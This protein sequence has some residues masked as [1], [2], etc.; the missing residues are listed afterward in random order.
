LLCRDYTAVSLCQGSPSTNFTITIGNTDLCDD[1]PNVDASAGLTTSLETYYDAALQIPQA[2]FQTGDMVYFKLAVRDPSST[3]DQITFRSIIVR[4]SDAVVEDDL[5]ETEN[6]GDLPSEA[7]VFRADADFNIT[8][9]FRTPFLV[10]N[11]EGDL[12]FNFRLLRNKLQVVSALSSNSADDMTKQLTI[13]AVIDLLYH[14]NQVVTRTFVA[15]TNIPAMTHAQ[16]SFYD[17]GET[18]EELEPHANDANVAADA[19][20]HASLFAASPASTVVASCVAVLAAAA[21]ILA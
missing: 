1:A 15:T 5:Y 10:P 3:I 2:I 8:Q 17:M 7:T 9:E 6:A 13:E 12:M 19:A 16:I 11:A 14:G 20:D 18:E 4:S 21:V